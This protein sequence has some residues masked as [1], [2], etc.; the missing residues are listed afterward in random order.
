MIGYDVAHYREPQ[1]GASSASRE[2]WQEEFVTVSSADPMTRVR[3]RKPHRVGSLQVSS[4]KCYRPLIGI[5]EGGIRSVP[6][7]SPIR[8][9]CFN[10]VVDQVHQ[11]A[12][13]LF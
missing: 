2:F 6:I 13:Y 12:L 4:L 11:N 3:Y 9:Q 10:G 1:S 5:L 7:F 8:S